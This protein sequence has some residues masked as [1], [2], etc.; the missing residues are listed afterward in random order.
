MGPGTAAITVTTA[1]GGKTAT[2]RFTVIIYIRSL[3][4]GE[5]P[6]VIVGESRKVSVW[7]YPEDATETELIWKSDD[8]S[9]APA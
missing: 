4:M 5:I 9:I 7:W 3:D 1:D 6:D 2:C 8:P